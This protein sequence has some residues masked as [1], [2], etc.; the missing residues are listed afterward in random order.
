VSREPTHRPREQ[1]ATIAYL[2][3]H[4]SK[5]HERAGA[6]GAARLDYD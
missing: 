6:L 3:I 2:L 1:R 5:S 4:F